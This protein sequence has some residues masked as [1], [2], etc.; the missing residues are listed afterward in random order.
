MPRSINAIIIIVLLFLTACADWGSTSA[1]QIPLQQVP[2]QRRHPAASLLLPT[3]T[4]TQLGVGN[5]MPLLQEAKQ[6]IDVGSST[7]SS[8][9]I[10]KEVHPPPFILAGTSPQAIRLRKALQEVWN[11]VP[12]I[13]H[14]QLF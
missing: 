10:Q 6:H 1:F 12:R 11:R 3:G 9:N 5:V 8:D 13:K 4:S 2:S 14:V 7:S